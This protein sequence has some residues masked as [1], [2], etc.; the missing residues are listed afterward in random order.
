MMESSSSQDDNEEDFRWMS[1][2]E[3]TTPYYG[4]VQSV[5]EAEKTLKE[6]SQA[7][8]SKYVVYQKDKAFGAQGIVY[9]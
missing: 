9:T 6:F 8:G 5:E 3:W 4:Y 7:T 1:V 2:G